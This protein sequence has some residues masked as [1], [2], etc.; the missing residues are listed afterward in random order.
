MATRQ[1]S[2]RTE[3]KQRNSSEIQSPKGKLGV[4]IPGMGAVATTS[5][6]GSKPY[7]RES[8]SPS[9]PLPR[10]EPF[11]WQAHRCAVSQ[12]QG[13]R[14]SGR[15]RRSGLHR[16]GH[17]RRRHVRRSQERRGSRSRTA[18]P[19]QAVP[20]F[21]QAA[22]SSFRHNYVKK[23]D[24]PNVKKGKNK[25]DLAEQVRPIFA[26]SKSLLERHA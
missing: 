14:S 12:N 17:F 16:L 23:I 7:A 18:R 6:L 22:Q 10:W 9:V 15:T 8:P 4:M 1:K 5:W 21:D 19:G 26:T 2:A 24:G 25:M 11:A 3:S 20:G 13:V